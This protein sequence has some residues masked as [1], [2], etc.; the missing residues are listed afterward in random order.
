MICSEARIR[1]SHAA[2]YL[3]T[4]CERLGAAAPGEGAR[5]LAEIGM[6]GG[7]CRLQA[8]AERLVIACSAQDEAEVAAMQRQVESHFPPPAEGDRFEFRWHTVT[9]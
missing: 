8:D 7:S 1:T 3:A 2:N 4:L 5:S 6:A 9:L